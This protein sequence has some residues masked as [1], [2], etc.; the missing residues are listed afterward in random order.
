MPRA[1][2]LADNYFHAAELDDWIEKVTELV[3]LRRNGLLAPK[4][5][6]ER[7]GGRVRDDVVEDPLDEDHGRRQGGRAVRHAALL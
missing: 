6:R 4:P 2:W 1:E 7:A 5:P 3:D